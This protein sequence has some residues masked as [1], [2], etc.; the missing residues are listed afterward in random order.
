MKIFRGWNWCHSS[1][2]SA[3]DWQS[4]ERSAKEGAS[5]LLHSSREDEASTTIK[6]QDQHSSLPNDKSSYSSP[7]S[8][9]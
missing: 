7:L 4:I 1:I 6:V 8:E 3:G 5:E 9:K 2:V